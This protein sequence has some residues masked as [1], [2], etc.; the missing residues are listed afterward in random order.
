MLF[1]IITR[2]ANGSV[3]IKDDLSGFS[4]TYYGYSVK[5]AEQ[6]HRHNYNLVGKHF[7]KIIRMGN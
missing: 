7:H 5:D 4:V 3:H 2:N 6:K 1:I